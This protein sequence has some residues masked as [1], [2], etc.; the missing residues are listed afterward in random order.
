MFALARMLDDSKWMQTCRR[1][2]LERHPNHPLRTVQTA[3]DDI[4]RGDFEEAEA[5]LRR[6]VRTSRN[7]DVLYLL[8]KVILEQGGDAEEAHALL[9]GAVVQQ[10]FT[11]AFRLARADVRIILGRL[12]EADFDLDILRQIQPNNLDFLLVELRRLAAEGDRRS[13]RDAAR[14]LAERRS[15]LSGAQKQQLKHVL[16]ALKQP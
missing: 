3:W 11:H 4:Q 6:T 16:A 7:P 14:K 2:L 9:T 1:N 13:A 12:D 8:A 5:T 15:E 10:P